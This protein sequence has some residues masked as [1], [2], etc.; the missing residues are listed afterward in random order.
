MGDNMKKMFVFFTAVL[1]GAAAQANDFAQSEKIFKQYFIQDNNINKCLFPDIY[2]LDDR[3]ATIIEKLWADEE[4]GGRLK[5]AHY[6]KLKIRLAQKIMPLELSEQFL[7]NTLSFDLQQEYE[8]AQKRYNKTVSIKSNKECE[9]IG[10]YAT[11][12]IEEYDEFNQ[13]WRIDF[14][15]P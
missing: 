12:L 10:E 3:G 11:K 5:R 9:K 14:P 4:N 2:Q 6:L 13:K 15:N 1:L 7:S 8:Q